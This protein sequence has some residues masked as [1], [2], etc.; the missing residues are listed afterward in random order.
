MTPKPKN[1]EPLFADG[2]VGHD[3]ERHPTIKWVWTLYVFGLITPLLEFNR[4]L[5]LWRGLMEHY[6]L[7]DEPPPRPGYLFLVFCVVSGAIIAYI[8]CRAV[9]NSELRIYDGYI[10][11]RG[12]KHGSILRFS[13]DF[14]IYYSQIKSVKINRRALVVRCDDGKYTVWVHDPEA[15]YKRIDDRLP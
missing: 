1:T 8:T 11:G 4:R 2:G 7:W 12:F 9:R 14:R 13:R 3:G 6:W 15:C 10:V 5:G